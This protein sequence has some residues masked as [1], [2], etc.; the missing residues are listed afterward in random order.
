[1]YANQS[2]QHGGV[3]H[4]DVGEVGEERLDLWICGL[5]GHGIEKNVTRPLGLQ[6]LI[7]QSCELSIHGMLSWRRRAHASNRGREEYVKTV[8]LLTISNIFMT[9]A[10]YG[11]LR[12]RQA[13]LWKVILVSWL[14]AFLEYCFQVPANRIGYSQ[15]SA[16]QL[17]VL[18]EVITLI[19][20]CV[21]SVVYLKEDLK[22]NYLVGFLL[23][24]GAVFFV[25][26][27]W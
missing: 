12:Y 27:K 8:L 2:F 15:F 14:I 3:T 13:V 7:E 19:V 18:Q 26:K 23:I 11:H 22:W 20:F 16:A 24:A 25:F 17:K 10:W 9:I 4:F 5:L 21:F 6:E 1:M